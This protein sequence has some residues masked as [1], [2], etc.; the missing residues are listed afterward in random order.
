MIHEANIALVVDDR[1]KECRVPINDP[2]RLASMGFVVAQSD[3]SC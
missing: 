1:A 2:L 3:R